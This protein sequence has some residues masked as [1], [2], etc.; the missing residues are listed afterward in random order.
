MD[1]VEFSPI[2]PGYKAYFTAR[3]NYHPDPLDMDFYY[4]VVFQPHPL[5]TVS[6]PIRIL[7]SR[8]IE[9]GG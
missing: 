4:N 6:L 2:T 7:S 1:G 3:P 5:D 8:K 9:M